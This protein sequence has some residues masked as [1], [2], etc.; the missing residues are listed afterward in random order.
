VNDDARPSGNPATLASALGP[1]ALRP[2]L[3]VWFAFV[4]NNFPNIS[5][6]NIS[7]DNLKEKDVFSTSFNITYI[8]SKYICLFI[9]LK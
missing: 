9:N 5:K 4:F 8:S 1:L 6:L 2:T 7:G 3:S